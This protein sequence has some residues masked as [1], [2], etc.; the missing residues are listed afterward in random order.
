MRD[1][2]E[3]TVI[4]GRY[5]TV[6]RLGSG[7]M[8]DVYC[9]SDEQLGRYVALKLLYARYAED[10][11]FVERFRREASS[12]AALQHPHVVSVFDRGEWD[13][14][15]YIAMEYLEGRSLKTLVQQE[16]PLDPVR[17]IDIVM[18]ILSAARFAHQRG[19]IHR[20][21]K[22]HNVIV[23]DEDRV[24]VT[25]FGIA[26]AGASDVTQTGSIMG[27]AQ[28]LS[29][30]QAQ[31][32]AVSAASDLYSIGIVLYE[33]LTGRVPFEGPS[34]VTIALKQVSEAPVAPSAYNV[35]VTPELDAV[36]LCALEKDPLTRYPSADDFIAGLEQ[37]RA[38]LLAKVGIST[39]QFGAVVPPAD[40]PPV[41]PAPAPGGE[42]EAYYPPEE[43]PPDDGRRRWPW[44]ILLLALIA[45]L[46]IAGIVLLPTEKRQVPDVSGNTVAGATATLRHAGLKV[47]QRPSPSI[48][49]RQ[50]RVI[51]TD[52]PAH[53]QV[54]RGSTV[55]LVVSTGPS[56]TQ[57]PN[58]AL[59]PHSQ[60]VRLL[61]QAGFRVSERREPSDSIARNHVIRTEP[62][63][64]TQAPQGSTVTMTLSRGRAQVVV[65]RVV[66]KQLDEARST[67]EAA[68]FQV[69]TA[70]RQSDQKEG[71]VLDQSPTADT[72][73]PKGSKVTLTVAKKSD[74][75]AVTDVMGLP[76]GD[77]INALT[78]DGFQTST[79]TRTAKTPD[80][81]GKVIK[82]RPAA[83]RK[84]KRGST[85]TVTVGS[86]RG[87]TGPPGP[88]QTTPTPPRQ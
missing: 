27:T 17:A 5:R 25:D 24:K 69:G 52:P 80:Q 29:P 66:G 60:A 48:S 39:A 54:S 46:A 72:N 62:P 64:F 63:A 34:A 82:Q 87:G 79:V 57:V 11:E 65:P 36:V 22:P 50:G 20:D 68:G 15:Y 42:E 61:R 74:K 16:G 75:V 32:H 83:G 53:A 3:G 35:R 31:G 33:M 28:Y 59:L 67:L 6:S 49:V 55:T 21:L 51:S 71:T 8:A 44:V 23:D 40:V 88:G 12:A 81:D 56:T 76:E 47:A 19:V 38:G 43:V 70:Q 85:V 37:A 77:A 7:G 1:L 13:G 78:A 2:P 84:V 30:E 45:A 14:T 18:Q 9:A 58:V 10:Q 41:I 86:F 4:D 26:R 73:A